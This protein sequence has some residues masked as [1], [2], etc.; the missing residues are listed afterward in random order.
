MERRFYKTLKIFLPFKLTKLIK[1][2]LF[3]IFLS[4]A[5][6]SVF[7]QHQDFSERIQVHLWAEIDAFPELEEAQNLEA[8]TFD[9][10]I[11]RIR[12]IGPYLLNGMVYG[13]NFS[14]TPS[15]KMRN[16]QEFFELTEIGSVQNGGNQIKYEKPWIQDNLLHCWLEYERTPQ[17]IWNLKAWN[18]ISTEKIQGKGYGKISS[19]FKGIQDAA[20]DAVKE[21]VRAHYRAILK[22][23]PKQIDGKVIIRSAPKIGLRSGRYIVELD[24]FLETDRIM[25]YIQF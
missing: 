20:E 16:V 1:L 4:G 17:E 14:Y 6:F 21:A 9:F 2:K 7:A 22:N 23:K 12:E 24:F 19:G 13:W 18:S 5:V 25:K 11:N 8:G 15:D 3:L 10:A